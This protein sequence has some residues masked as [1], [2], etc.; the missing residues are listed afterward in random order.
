M[1]SYCTTKD[2]NGKTLYWRV[3]SDGRRKRVKKTSTKGKKVP[4]CKKHVSR[5]KVIS[6]GPKAELGELPPEILE[7]ITEEISPR[8]REKLRMTSKQLREKIKKPSRVVW[9]VWSKKNIWAFRRFKEASET[10]EELT[11]RGLG[12][13][14]L[15]RLKKGS[16]AWLDDEDHIIHY[17]QRV[18]VY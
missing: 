15:E 5:S 13:Y 16:R 8:G 7:M 4:G 6:R 14:E 12:E 3:M 2:K 11:G 17:I 10:I 9:V 1:V 18:P